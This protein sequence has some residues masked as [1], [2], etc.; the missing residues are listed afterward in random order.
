[1]L[2]SNCGQTRRNGL[3]RRPSLERLVRILPLSTSNQGT[4]DLPCSTP[5]QLANL[6]L[7][8][9]LVDCNKSS[10]CDA[11]F[12]IFSL[13]MV[14][15]TPGTQ[16]VDIHGCRAAP[17]YSIRRPRAPFL[18]TSTCNHAPATVPRLIA[19]YDFGEAPCPT[20]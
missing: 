13:V 2:S 17:I 16:V 20:T 6:A 7:A 12:S 1:M 10:H 11:S 4:M 18:T 9:G 3:P 5:R 19:A 8:D 15:V 14:D